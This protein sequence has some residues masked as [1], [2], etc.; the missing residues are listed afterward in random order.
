M[1]TVFQQHAMANTLV[2]GG[3]P[4]CLCIR[5]RANTGYKPHMT[6]LRML[7]T[8]PAAVI[9]TIEYYYSPV[10]NQLDTPSSTKLNTL[11]QRM[12]DANLGTSRS[13]DYENAKSLPL[14][15]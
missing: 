3:F 1:M 5:Y 10:T 12:K 7:A 4:G 15:E 8:T 14:I 6:A 13:A 2:A 9:T 11:N